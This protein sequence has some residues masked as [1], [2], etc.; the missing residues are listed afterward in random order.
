MSSFIE[1]L[2]KNKMDKW[3]L[4]AAIAVVVILAI[5]IGVRE[6]QHYHQVKELKQQVSTAQEKSTADKPTVSVLPDN[7]PTPTPAQISGVGNVSSSMAK[8]FAKEVASKEKAISAGRASDQYVYTVDGSGD[9]AIAQF[10]QQVANGTAPLEVKKADFVTATKT[11]TGTTTKTTPD[12]TQQT[13]QQSTVKINSYYN[14]EPSVYYVPQAYPDTLKRHDII[15]TN[16][17]FLFD[18]N[19]DADRHGNKFGASV[20]IRLCKW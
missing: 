13:V 17:D 16:R 11:D 1:N 9:D 7:T 18:A 19:Y 10:N 20:G 14:Y 2:T 15:Y 12:G 8:E 6:Y 3:K 4:Y 5:V